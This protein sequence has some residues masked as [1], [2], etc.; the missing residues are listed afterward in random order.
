VPLVV[1]VYW[2][3]GGFE[4][5]LAIS[6]SEVVDPVESV[7]GVF[8][9]CLRQLAKVDLFLTR[10]LDVHPNY[11]LVQVNFRAR[12]TPVLRCGLCSSILIVQIFLQT[13]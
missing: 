1:F 4:T 13:R 3:V 2:A 11:W 8:P 12:R 5:A 7:D 6:P 9:L 10:L